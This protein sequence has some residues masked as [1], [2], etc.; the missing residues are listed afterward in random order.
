GALWAKIAHF[1]PAMAAGAVLQA[2]WL[3]ALLALAYLAWLGRGP[4]AR[5]VRL[6]VASSLVVYATVVTLSLPNPRYLFPLLPMLIVVA[7]AGARRLA[8]CLGVRSPLAT[9][10]LAALLVG[11]PAA[12]TLR[13]WR[14][15]W[16]AGVSDR[17]GFT[18]SEWRALNEG[19][20]RRL[21]AGAVV[22]SDI[23][24]QLAWYTEHAAVLI[25]NAPDGLPE[26]ER[27]LPLGALV[28]TNHWLIG[29]PGSEAWRALFFAGR[30][31]PGWSRADSVAAGRLR[32]VLFL[33]TR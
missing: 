8:E 9:A 1:G 17:G 25:P 12:E 16:P 28:L 14:V 19:L 10:A 4:E 27:R 2:G 20:R 13:L 33:P 6:T 3:M 22:A 24:P 7:V 29:R 11:G 32:A 15:A 21:P 23:G 5:P 31:L 18:E 26:I 30:T